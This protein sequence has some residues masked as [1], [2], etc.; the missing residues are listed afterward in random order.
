MIPSDYKHEMREMDWFRKI[1]RIAFAVIFLN[2]L[3]SALISEVASMSW[4]CMMSISAISG[5]SWFNL[6]RKRGTK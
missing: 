6:R 5:I 3:A 2:T 1:W 4:W